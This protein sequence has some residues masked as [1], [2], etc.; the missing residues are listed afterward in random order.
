[1]TTMSWFEGEADIGF[2]DRALYDYLSRVRR[3]NDWA[4]LI[5]AFYESPRKK[6]PRAARSKVRVETNADGFPK[7]TLAVFDGCKIHGYWDTPDVGALGQV[8][9]AM[10]SFLA[11]PRKNVALG[12]ADFSTDGGEGFVFFVDYD[13]GRIY[14]VYTQPVMRDFS[15]APLPGP[16]PAETIAARRGAAQAGDRAKY[17]AQLR[18]R[19]TLHVNRKTRRFFLYEDTSELRRYRLRHNLFRGVLDDAGSVTHE[20]LADATALRAR[21]DD[22]RES[23]CKKVTD[24]DLIERTYI[25]V[26]GASTPGKGKPEKSAPNASRRKARAAR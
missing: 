26:A 2:R 11:R 12:R 21:A 8:L 23:G 16:L 13:R 18:A 19:V 1:M 5:C 22:L 3:K 9:R 10:G 14:A 7:L 25:L 6:R 15:T 24:L 17:L 4:E 20:V